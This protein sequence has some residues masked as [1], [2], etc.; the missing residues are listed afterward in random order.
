MIS[1]KLLTHTRW[2]QTRNA[3]PLSRLTRAF[4]ESAERYCHH[5]HSCKRERDSAAICEIVRERAQ[6]THPESH[7]LI[8]RMCSILVFVVCP[9]RP[10][11]YSV[12]SRDN[13]KESVQECTQKEQADSCD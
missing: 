12:D 3:S 1:S 2:V 6:G 4:N 9:V 7:A 5:Y 11:G 8:L 10:R 13:T